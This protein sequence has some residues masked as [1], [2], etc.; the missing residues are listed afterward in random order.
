[1]M[2]KGDAASIIPDRARAATSKMLLLFASLLQVRS[3]RSRGMDSVIIIICRLNMIIDTVLQQ[4][5]G[6]PKDSLCHVHVRPR[7]DPELT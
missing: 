5:M 7:D 6:W 3:A 4:H 2:K 1:M